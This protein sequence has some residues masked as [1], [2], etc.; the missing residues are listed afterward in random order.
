MFSVGAAILAD[1]SQNKENEQEIRSQLGVSTLKVWKEVKLFLD[2]K[3]GV[4]NNR[5][6]DYQKPDHQ[7]PD[8]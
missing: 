3:V 5:L 1:L 2:P 8:Y 6:S 4:S 7:E